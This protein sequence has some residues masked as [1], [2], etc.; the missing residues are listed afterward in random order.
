LAAER[1]RNL[2]ALRR[3]R[4]WFQVTLSSIGDAVVTVDMAGR[5]TF[6]NPVSAELTGRPAA[7]AKGESIQKLFRI[8]DE[9]SREPV[10]DVLCRVLREGK[11]VPLANHT[12]LAARDGREI[13]IEDTAA[14]IRDEAGKVAGVVLVFRD[15]TEKRRTQQERELTIEFLRLVNESTATHDLV[16]RAATFFQQQSRCDAVGV[17][18][19][20]GGDY[21]D[22][23]WTNYSTELLA[24]TTEAE[25]Q[26]RT[27]NRCQVEGYQSVALIPLRMGGQDLGLL[28][29]NDRRPGRF[30]AELIAL[31]ER[32][33]GHLAVALAKFDAEAALRESGERYRSLFENMQE[34]FAYCQMCFEGDQPQDFIYLEV[35]CAF[36]KLTGLSQA[37][38]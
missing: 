10:E 26:A 22:N 21:P 7:E 35:N 37:V 15:V 2:E 6:M 8:I 38:G 9:S 13:P 25:R 29:L 33:A 5:V 3:E 16:K 31:W 18:L 32:L 20:E 30:T 23:F 27:R 11:V 34:G 24:G 17:R 36:E 1:Q 12:A 28:Q 4:E 14:P 19:K